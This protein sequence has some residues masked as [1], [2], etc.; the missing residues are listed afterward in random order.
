MEKKGDLFLIPCKVN[1]LPMK[2]IFDTGASD[3][4]ISLIEASFMLR[5]GYL[6]ED[7]I[8]SSV[9]YGIA[10]GN[11]TEGT[12]IILKR[13]EVGNKSL[14]N[15]EATIIHST[16]AP[17]LF[18][19]S[20]MKKFGNFSFDYNKNTLT[21]SN[22]NSSQ[23][24]TLKGVKIGTQTWATENLDVTTFRNG[25]EIPEVKT[26][27]EWGN[28]Y[29]NHQPAWCYYNND[30]GLRLGKLYNWYAV[31]D[32]RGLAPKGWKIPTHKEWEQ[33]IKYLDPKITYTKKEDLLDENIS[34]FK[35]Y[36][37][38]E[39]LKGKSGWEYSVICCD[40]EIC[41]GKCNGN[42]LVGFNSLPSSHR[43]NYGHF[44]T[45]D[46]AHYWTS[47]QSD[48]GA[49]NGD[50]GPGG[51]YYVEIGTGSYREDVNGNSIPFESS[52]NY[53][54]WTSVQ[55]YFAGPLNGLS[56][57]CVKIPPKK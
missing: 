42:N 6:T 22:S 25:D 44:M 51:G 48:F 12:R 9:Y 13:L 49:Y 4:C 39:K 14:I 29:K 18:G 45:N 33:L 54:D 40:D 31:I 43:N 47:T 23:S 1:G 19:Q 2:F 8:G 21:I 53:A 17:L 55:L 36:K 5:N 15:V 46:G 50:S 20:A 16:D 52:G 35:S 38:D 10:N 27:E 11:I 34:Q 24:K 3:V 26:R 28:L 37:A 7:E 41:G 32:P 56:V 30:E 57:R